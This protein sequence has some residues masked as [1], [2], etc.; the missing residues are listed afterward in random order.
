MLPVNHGYLAVFQLAVR[1]GRKFRMF[2]CVFL[3][4]L[5]AGLSAAADDFSGARLSDAMQHM[6]AV[7]SS[8][9]MQDPDVLQAMGRVPRHEFVPEDNRS[10]SYR[11][12]PLPIG[13]G[14]T[15]SQPYI[16]AE[17]TRQLRLSPSSKVLEIGT[18]S[19]YQAAVLAELTPTVYSI[20]IIEPLQERASYTLVCV[21]VTATTAGPRPHLLTVSLSPVPPVKY[22]RHWLSSLPSAA[23]C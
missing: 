15:I 1:F 17:M 20:E 9:G 10:Y 4:L 3:A 23:E 2:F 18:G 21:T 6:L 14:Q 7:I 12:T 5:H 16:V 22:R 19:G 13:Y 11:D 8:Y